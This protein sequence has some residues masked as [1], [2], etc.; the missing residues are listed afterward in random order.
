MG[1]LSPVPAYVPSIRLS[2]CGHCAPRSDQDIG[3]L[4]TGQH[5]PQGEHLGTFM[6]FEWVTTHWRRRGKQ[7]SRPPS[8]TTG[9]GPR[10]AKHSVTHVPLSGCNPHGCWPPDPSGLASL[11]DRRHTA[12]SS[13]ANLSLH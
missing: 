1:V 3:M 5:R 4:S 12:S 10:T 7:E 6:N 11:A 9:G 8:P 13:P 2:G